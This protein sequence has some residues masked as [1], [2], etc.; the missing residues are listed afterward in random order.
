MVKTLQSTSGRWIPPEEPA[1]VGGH[2]IPGGLI[3]LGGYLPCASGAVEP[4]LINPDLPVSP[5]A[6]R[7]VV[8]VAGRELAYHLLS[9]AARRAYLDWQA[10]G[11]RADV[12]PGLVL[13][14]CFGI[15]RRVLVDGDDDPA[16][17]RDLPALTAEVRRLRIR[18][19]GGGAPL[20]E[21]LDHL[22]DLLTLLATPGT[23]ATTP[24]PVL[25]EPTTMAVRIALARFAVASCP[26]PAA[27]AR[28]WI[29]QHPSLAPRRSEIDCPAEFDRLFTLRYHDR[30]GPGVVP[31]GDAGGI[32]L[33]Y[34]PAS[35]GLATT[36]V[37][38]ADLPD[39][40]SEPRSTRA[41]V[42]LRDDVAAALDP[43][44]R[45]LVRFPQG[46]DSLAAV[47]L[48][49]AELVD[50]RH[51]TLGAVRVW[52]ERRLDGRARATIDA[53]EF[54]E[55]WST[56][57]PERM[58]ADE[59][60]ALLAVLSRLDF[61]VEPDVRFGAPALT[62]G[63]AVLFRLGRPAA[64][65]PSARFLAAAAIAR[66]AAAVASAA[67]PVDTLG[68]SVAALLATTAD[69]AAGLRLAPGEDLRLAAR[70]GWLL[71]TRVD[72]DRL[73][74]QT[75]ML[76]D[77][78]R[79]LAGHYLIS[80]A[81]AADPA[82][83]P[84]AV[85]LLTRVYRILGLRPDLVFP[86]LH[87]RSTGGAPVPPLP[88]GSGDPSPPARRTAAPAQRTAATADAQAWDEP[89]VVQVGDA[90]PSGFALPWA[91]P[92]AVA[93][94]TPGGVRLDP[95]VIRQKV[96][97]S[98]TAAALLSTIFE[99][100]QEA[101]QEADQ[102]TDRRAEQ[103]P[104]RAAEPPV[105]YVPSVPGLD[106]AHDG[107]LRALA[108]RPGWT[109]EEFVSLAARHGVMPDG[110]L[111]LLNEVALDTAG[112]PLIEGDVTLTVANDVLLELLA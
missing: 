17:Q 91:T 96:A 26:V 31:S 38:R 98:G 61:G 43:Y 2:A 8:P 42:A 109:R 76:T 1:A 54:S 69:L 77:A 103:A 73:G 78:E 62:V 30:F 93:G 110:A 14:F 56:A 94:T 51:G 92:P 107:L 63:P 3:Y 60:S 97:E 99:T 83:G 16:V 18:Y 81:V 32:R 90:R 34:R 70:L 13:L 72:V 22:L 36:L 19:A 74:R 86:R 9:P 48:L 85:G 102:E 55:F 46:R 52:A 21:A 111:D 65:R 12:A 49:P 39:L 45:W 105:T 11:R 29:R 87:E 10:G 28:A 47:P 112:A 4:S 57:T 106:R 41:L 95:A 68:P 80:V 53:G 6:G 75:T 25:D 101:E 40:L 37:C 108:A 64:G 27:W 33:R 5:S 79:E 20:R 23:A 71:T 89:V 7:H 104:S 59:A 58:A 15:E 84:A 67:G 100:E 50:A 82:V 88:I 35:P 44:R 24:A 66:C